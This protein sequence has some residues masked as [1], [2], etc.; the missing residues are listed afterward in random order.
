MS[1]ATRLIAELLQASAG[2]HSPRAL[3]RAIAVVLGAHARLL[4]VELQHPLPAAIAERVGTEWR[5]AEAASTR[6]ALTVIA[7]GLAVAAQGAL[8]EVLTEH[9][10]QRA[11]AGVMDMAARHLDVVQRLAHL[12]RKAQVSNRELRADL[13]RADDPGAVVANSPRMRTALARIAQVARHPTTVLLLG[14]SGSGKE[15][16]ARELHRRS[17]RA[18]RAMLQLN[19]AAIPEALI[20]S[21]LFGHERGAFTGAERAHAGVFERAH[22]STLLLDEVGELSPAA[23]AK[24]LRVLQEG[25]IRRVGGETEVAID[26][27]LVAAT[28]RSLADMVVAGTFREDLYYRLDVFSIEV[29][30]LRDRSEDLAPLVDAIGRELATRMGATLPPIS[31]GLLAKLA[32]HD[33]PG[34]VRELRNLLES[35]LVL[36]G[37]TAFVLPEVFP[38]RSTARGPRKFDA[39]VRDTIEEVLRATHGKLYGANG[40]A[41]RLGMPPATLQSKMKKLG[42]ERR[43]FV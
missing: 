41:A 15:V 25:T 40:A 37:G 10:V 26:V 31:R 35:A 19:C 16:L 23:Q 4:R 17:P 39:A 32:A 33:W 8:P 29:P 12:S 43:R 38:R 3:V 13:E 22:R 27:R 36:G 20:E 6:R 5:S 42:I 14:E 28:H 9:E 11:I 21:E 30:S 2:V 24:L 7:P 18:H 1:A 34:N